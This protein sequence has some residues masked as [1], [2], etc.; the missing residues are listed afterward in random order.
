MDRQKGQKEVRESWGPR[1]VSSKRHLCL[2]H[3]LLLADLIS[4]SRLGPTW[5]IKA[6]RAGGRTEA[7][8]QLVENLE[9]LS[10]SFWTTRHMHTWMNAHSHA[11]ACALTHTDQVH[12][13][14]PTPA[15]S[16]AAQQDL[17][18]RRVHPWRQDISQWIAD[19][20][21]YPFSSFR[22]GVR[23]VFKGLL[24]L[25]EIEGSRLWSLSLECG[26][27]YSWLLPR[28]TSTQA[29]QRKLV[30]GGIWSSMEGAS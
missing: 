6:L 21:F 10:I 24:C 28:S 30:V 13:V 15:A 5:S 2:S 11:D 9:I 4:G 8:T 29:Q 27:S 17:Q 22:Y 25:R 7:F 26:S 14:L 19:L 18:V 20:C 1:T 12:V 16:S 23:L 3:I